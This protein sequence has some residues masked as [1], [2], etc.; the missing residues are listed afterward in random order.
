LTISNVK[1]SDGEIKSIAKLKQIA[2]LRIAGTTVS[3]QQIAS[4]VAMP[5]L[6]VLSLGGVD[7]KVASGKATRIPVEPGRWFDGN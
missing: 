1:L 6:K 4:L 3:A 7:Y 2:Y 5:Q